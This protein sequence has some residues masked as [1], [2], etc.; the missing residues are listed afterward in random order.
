MSRLYIPSRREFLITSST[1]ALT[2]SFAV[3][4]DSLKAERI[5]LAQLLVTRNVA[6]NLER[7]TS[8]IA[9]AKSDK[10]GWIFFPEGMLSG[11]YGGFRQAEVEEA[12]KQIQVQCQDA[13]LIGLIGT[14][15]QEDAAKPHNEIRIVDRNGQTVSRYAKTCLTYGDAKQ[16]AA[17]DFPLVHE[18]GGLKIG[19]LIC[20]DLWVTPGY[21]DGPNPHLTLKQAR[22]GAQVIFHAVSSGADPRYRAYHESNQALRAAEA[23]CP[24][25]SVNS[26][27]ENGEGNCTSGVILPT[28]EYACML[29]RK[30][31]AVETVEFTPKSRQ[32]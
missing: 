29:P 31:E 24:I 3:S 12:F 26:A 23:G 15:W 7:M 20:N 18:V 32:A 1:L 14:C 16:F 9:Q 21:S 2:S 25:V 28:M 17:G 6:R 19:T 13:G 10:A 30:G 27:V 11:Y 8:A 4:D 22:A 5:T